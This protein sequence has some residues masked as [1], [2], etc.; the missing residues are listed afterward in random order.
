MKGDGITGTTTCQRCA[1]Q[2]VWPLKWSQRLQQTPLNRLTCQKQRTQTQA[3][4]GCL[5]V[6]ER[7]HTATTTSEASLNDSDAQTRVYTG[8][9]KSAPV[10]AL[11]LTAITIPHPLTYTG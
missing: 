3:T 7:V 11:C 8:L 6:D 9:P 4:A 2:R 1:H 5:E 10:H